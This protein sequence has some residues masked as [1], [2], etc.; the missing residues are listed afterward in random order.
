MN[1]VPMVI[2]AS[3]PQKDVGLAY[4]FLL[5]FGLW[6]GHRFYLGQPAMGILYFFTAGFCGIMLLLD[7]FTLSD[8]V[9]K[10]NKNSRQEAQEEANAQR[11]MMEWQSSVYRGDTD[12]PRY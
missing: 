1:Q 9:K 5:V 11:E 2:V 7:L 8:D 12:E 10:W 3:A 6:G 4:V